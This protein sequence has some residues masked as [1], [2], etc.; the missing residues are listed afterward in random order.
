[1]KNYRHIEV[2]LDYDAGDMCAFAIA[3]DEEIEWEEDPNVA[4]KI[5]AT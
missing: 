3:E 5:T 2:G 1:M 4:S